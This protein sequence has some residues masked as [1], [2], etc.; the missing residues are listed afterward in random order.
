MDNY[1]FI[2]FQYLVPKKFI[3]EV[4]GF[5]AKSQNYYIKTFFIKNFQKKYNVNLK[6]AIYED[7]ELYPSFNSFFTRELKPESRPI[8]ENIQSIIS[9]A[10]G[11]VSQIGNINSGKI[12][13][14]KGIYFNLLSFLGNDKEYF[15]KFKEGVFCTVY[16]SPKDYHRVHMPIDGKLSHMVYIPGKLF[17]VN[18]VTSRNV[19]NLY[20]INERLICFFDTVRGPMSVVLVGAMIVSGITVQWEK[21][22][23]FNKRKIQ[24]FVYPSIGKDSVFLKKGDEVGRFMLGSTVV[25]CFGKNK[26]N[27]SN[28][29]SANSIVKMGQCM[30]RF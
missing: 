12:I 25:V 4:I 6:E 28:K 17:S 3:S 1:L 14:A 16:L 27:W 20:S 18:K 26:V 21:E 30:G 8:D 13:Q 22:N 2:L 24:K 7:V 29:I 15:E 11:V 5:F 9:P 23:C 19:K 10:D